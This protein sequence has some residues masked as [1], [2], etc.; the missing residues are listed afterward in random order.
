[1]T[2]LTNISERQQ[3]CQGPKESKQK[4]KQNQKQLKITNFDELNGC[5]KPE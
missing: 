3:M 2:V 1:V 4:Q 5:D